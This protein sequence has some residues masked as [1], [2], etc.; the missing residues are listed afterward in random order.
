MMTRGR[1]ANHLYVPVVGDGD[2]HTILRPENNELRTATELLQQILAR[3]PPHRLRPRCSNDLADQV[4]ASGEAA[5]RADEQDRI[6]PAGVIT[7]LQVWRAAMQ[8]EPADLR[9]TGPEQRSLLARTW[10]RRLNR[11]LGIHDTPQDQ[12]WAVLLTE[13]I[14]NLIKDSFL[15]S[16]TKRLQNLDRAG[17]DAASLVQ[18]AAAKAPLPDDH[19]QPH[20]GGAFSTNCP[21]RCQ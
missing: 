20:F 6:L 13:L 17:L 21:S 1:T 8:V 15:P 5:S 9:P 11:R 7:D 3:A 14:P 12:Q 4:C 16:L 19:R 10:Q 2:P 18:S